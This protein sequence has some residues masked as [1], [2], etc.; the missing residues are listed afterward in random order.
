MTLHPPRGRLGSERG[1]KIPISWLETHPRPC[2]V[3]I[4]IGLGSM[5]KKRT[6]RKQKPPAQ[7]KKRWTKEQIKILKRLY[8]THSNA[9][10]AEAVGRKVASVVY[11]AHRLGLYKGVRRMREMGRENIRHRWGE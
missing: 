4:S 9:D 8:K 2:L 6:R 10:I 7:V 5:A 3:G 11:K 1:I